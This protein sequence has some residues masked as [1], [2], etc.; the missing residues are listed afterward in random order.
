MNLSPDEAQSALE[1]IQLMTQKTRRSISNSGITLTLFITGVVWLVGYA[2][3]QFL[4]GPLVAY[5]W[6]GL[7]L[8]GSTLGVL[9]GSRMGR[10][11]RSP[12]T[13]VYARRIGIFWL[14]LVLY[15]AAVIA[16]ARPADGKQVTMLI[17]LFIMIGHF[18]AGMLLS[19]SYTWW[20][21][22]VTA[23]A[24]AGYYLLPAYFYL[25]MGVLGG[26][27]MIALALYIRSRW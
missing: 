25:W 27:G 2:C 7:S 3:T 17:I 5:I 10:R 23:L 11:V 13:S 20:A 18:A 24:L 21:L 15:A 22:P 1:A 4:T 19:Y 26:G 16:V 8:L 14:L 6:A 9:I 12:S